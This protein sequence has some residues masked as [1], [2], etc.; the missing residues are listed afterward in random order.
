M[1]IDQI[2][3]EQAARLVAEA[4]AD[5]EREARLAAEDR[6]DTAE[7]R[8]DTEREARLAADARADTAEA[9]IRELEEENERLRRQQSGQ[10]RRQR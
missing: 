9:R 4:R 7:A 2:V 1:S 3:P 5:T 8:A 10:Q 6:V